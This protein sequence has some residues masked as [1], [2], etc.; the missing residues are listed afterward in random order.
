MKNLENSPHTTGMLILFKLLLGILLLGPRFFC[1]H[2]TFSSMPLHLNNRLSLWK[3]QCSDLEPV[4]LWIESEK[5]ELPEHLARSEDFKFLLLCQFCMC[6]STKL[7]NS[8][9]LPSIV[10]TLNSVLDLKIWKYFKS[11]YVTAGTLLQSEHLTKAWIDKS[12]KR[13]RMLCYKRSDMVSGSLRIAGWGLLSEF[14]NIF[15]WQNN[16]LF[17]MIISAKHEEQEPETCSFCQ[18]FWHIL[19]PAVA[20][21]DA[22]PNLLYSSSYFWNK[23]NVR[24]VY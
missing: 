10:W 22:M 3:I 8:V 6:L 19:Q 15:V 16:F 12:L 18:T 9:L 20:K 14:E 11:S 17:N 23:S 24:Q 13:A 5:G 21:E 2:S 1:C 4:I 7:Y